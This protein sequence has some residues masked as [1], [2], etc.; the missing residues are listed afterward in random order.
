STMLPILRQV[1]AARD[2]ASFGLGAPAADDQQL[3][4]LHASLRDADWDAWAGST[5]HGAVPVADYKGPLPYPTPPPTPFGAHLSGVPAV[6]EAYRRGGR[7]AA[8]QV[9]RAD[10]P[11]L[12]KTGLVDPASPGKGLVVLFAKASVLA[13][14]SQATFIQTLSERGLLDELAPE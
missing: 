6:A 10:D 13:G 5:R 7:G 8:T 1:A 2:Q 11:S 14:V 9:L 12:M 4:A 3:A